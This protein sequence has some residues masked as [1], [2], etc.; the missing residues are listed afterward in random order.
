MAASTL[1][2][3]CV[4]SQRIRRNR[5]SRRLRSSRGSSRTIAVEARPAAVRLAAKIEFH[6]TVGCYRAEPEPTARRVEVRLQRHGRHVVWNHAEF[7]TDHQLA[8]DERERYLIA[9]AQHGEDGVGKLAET[10]Q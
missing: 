9:M 7:V 10:R 3:E 1:P 6:V 4:A 5:D 8:V 2:A